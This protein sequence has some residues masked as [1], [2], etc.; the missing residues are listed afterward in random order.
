[1]RGITLMFAFEEDELEALL[2]DR[3]ESLAL[4]SVNSCF[5]NSGTPVHKQKR[6]I[7]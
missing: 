2:L 6:T 1:M 3:V 4:P 7:L 5:G